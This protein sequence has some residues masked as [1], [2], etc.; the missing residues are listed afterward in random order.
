[1][2]AVC[3]CGKY[4]GELPANAHAAGQEQLWYS[5][6]QHH[7]ACSNILLT[8]AITMISFI[9]RLLLQ[10]PDR[11]HACSRTRLECTSRGSKMPSGLGAVVLVSWFHSTPLPLSPGSRDAGCQ[12]LA[13][14]RLPDRIRPLTDAA[15]NRE[16]QPSS[17]GIS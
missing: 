11:E 5:H 15:R 12:R 3:R 17:S 9:L 7:L 13:S 14:S 8:C 6:A 1:M 10:E 4:R 16:A 2:L